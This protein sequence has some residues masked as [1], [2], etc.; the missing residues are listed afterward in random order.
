MLEFVI[1]LPVFMFFLLFTLDV[2]SMVMQQAALQ[3]ATQQAART[4]AQRGGGGAA[5]A[6][7][8][9]QAFNRAVEAIPGM[10][11]QNIVFYGI[12]G[13][14]CQDA[15]PYVTVRARYR[16]NTMTPGLSALLRLATGNG[17]NADG[18]EVKATSVARCEVTR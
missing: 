11:A 10:T 12:E 2:R 13:A 16:V 15:N 18:W 17:V 6:G 5:D 4:G 3:D 8:S 9:R 14:V 7:A 1:L